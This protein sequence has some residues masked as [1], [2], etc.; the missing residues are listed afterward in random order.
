MAASVLS[1][2]E[3]LS[4]SVCCDVFQEP[5]LL[6]CGHSFCRKCLSRHWSSSPG[7]RCPV[8]R[9]PS[10]QEPV[11][12]ISLRSTCESF[13]KHQRAAKKAQMR[14]IK[15]R[16]QKKGEKDKLCPEHGRKL[17]FFCQREG[18]LVC[19][20][21]K[22]SGHRGHR[23][24][25][26][27]RAVKKRKRELAEATETWRKRLDALRSGSAD[28]HTSTADIKAVVEKCE[29]QMRKEFDKLF[30]FL[31]EEQKDRLEA[32]R[33]AGIREIQ[34]TRKAIEAE[35]TLLLNQIQEA[36]EMAQNNDIILKQ[37]FNAIMSAQ[38]SQREPARC[39]WDKIEV[40]ERLGNLRFHF[41][42]KMMEV[43]PSYLSVCV[44]TDQSPLDLLCDYVLKHAMA[45]G[46][47]LT[48]FDGAGAVK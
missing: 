15:K 40:A 18:E 2:E 10:P 12:N 19:C 26:W 45:A 35:A 47:K 24:L 27:Q 31:Q 41:C 17:V 5:V 20:Q 6:G 33:V 16:E 29:V 48:S 3:D 23:V 9:R 39:P 11:L 42:K 7:R 32:M 21:W 4:C 46:K 8:C 25:P 36:E 22:N 34:L 28:D 13:L 1:L 30:K 44:W 43:T 37:E 14:R 38:F